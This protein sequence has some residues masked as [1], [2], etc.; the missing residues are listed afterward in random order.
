MEGRIVTTG[1]EEGET[2]NSLM[3]IQFQ[4]CKIKKVLEICFPTVK[5]MVKRV[6]FMWFYY[7]LK[8]ILKLYI[9]FNL[10]G[11]MSIAKVWVCLWG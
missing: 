5:E 1:W 4:I 10:K 3:G 7:N 9:F 2:E 6:N 11:K 8:N